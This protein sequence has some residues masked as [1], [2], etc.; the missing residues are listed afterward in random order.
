MDGVIP[1]WRIP[2]SIPT[3]LIKFDQ[4][5]HTEHTTTEQGKKI[6]KEKGG[7]KGGEGRYMG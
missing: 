5:E 7:K 2:W 1:G 4:V 3:L 6:Q